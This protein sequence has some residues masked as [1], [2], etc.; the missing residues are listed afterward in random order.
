MQETQVQTLGQEDPLEKEMAIH[1]STLAWKI[2]WMEEPHRLQSM[3]LQRVRHDWATSLHNV[4]PVLRNI[5]NRKNTFAND[6]N[7][8]LIKIKKRVNSMI[9]FPHFTSWIK[10]HKQM[11]PSSKFL[12]LFCWLVVC[13]CQS[14]VRFCSLFHARE[15]A[16]SCGWR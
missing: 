15:A 14:W 11:S 12:P 4:K 9:K 16:R 1:S 10:T 13:E 2:P 8:K 5:L 7:L 6:K 3:G